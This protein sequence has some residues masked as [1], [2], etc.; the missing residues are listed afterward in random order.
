MN[1]SNK[2]NTSSQTKSYPYVEYVKYMQLPALQEVGGS[3]CRSLSSFKIRLEAIS[4]GI[5]T[6]TRRS[7]VENEQQLG[8]EREKERD[9]RLGIM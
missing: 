7:A 9:D 4:Q 6:R 5:G 3:F 8:R 1:H 2:L